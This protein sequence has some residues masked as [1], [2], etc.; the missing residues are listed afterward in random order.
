M[1]IGLK[2]SSFPHRHFTEHLVSAFGKSPW[3]YNLNHE[4]LSFSIWQLK[5]NTGRH[6]HQSTHKNRTENE[7]F[8]RRLYVLE[9]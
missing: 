9:K 2:N 8:I 1:K 3:E 6:L 5:S 4:T 7:T